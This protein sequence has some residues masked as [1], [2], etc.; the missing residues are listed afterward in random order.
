MPNKALI[1]GINNYK[2]ISGLNGCLTDV[3][4]MERLLRESFG[5]ESPSIRTLTDGDVVW[6]AII[7]GFNWLGEDAEAGD[8]LVF[9]FSGHGSFIP[10]DDDDETDDELICLWDMD[11][12]DP[13]SFMRDD[14]LRDLTEII[15]TGPRL[16]MVLDCCH[17]GT[18][19]RAFSAARYSLRRPRRQSRE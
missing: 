1:A 13:N 19:T 6:D 4:N 2:S 11:W 16:T 12:G 7:D 10:S 9:H 14:D 5:F 17:S 18:G 3:K 8:R 15:P